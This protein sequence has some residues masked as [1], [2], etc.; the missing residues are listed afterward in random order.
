MLVRNAVTPAAIAQAFGVDVP[1]I[2]QV[3]TKLDVRWEG[4]LV[5]LAAAE[6]GRINHRIFGGDWV[7]FGLVGDTHLCSTKCRLAEL[8]ATYKLFAEEGI[9]D[10]YHAGNIVDGYISRI[11]GGEVICTSIDDQTQYVIDHYP[12]VRGIT[13]HFITGDDHEG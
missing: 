5:T 13:T 1:T 11:N 12:Q 4:A 2:N 9:K 10:V 7:T 6:K 3:L 8:H